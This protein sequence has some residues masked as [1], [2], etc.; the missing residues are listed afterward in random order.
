M[1]EKKKSLK[2]AG[3]DNKKSGEEMGRVSRC[4]S[5]RRLRARERKMGFLGREFTNGERKGGRDS[6]TKIGRGTGDF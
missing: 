4:E 6:N 1:F 3:R 5:K 2:K